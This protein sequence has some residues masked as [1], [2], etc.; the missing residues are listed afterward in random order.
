M[1]HCAGYLYLP[2]VSL[3]YW[4]KIHHYLQVW[5]QLLIVQRDGPWKA[6]ITALHLFYLEAQN[7]AELTQLL[8]FMKSEQWQSKRNKGH[9]Q[10]EEKVSMTRTSGSGLG[11]VIRVRYSPVVAQWALSDETAPAGQAASGFR[12]GLKS[13]GQSSVQKHLQQGCRIAWRKLY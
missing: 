6:I 3:L 1:H 2:L 12:S 10:V 4:G 8:R 7:W 11:R 13:G 9:L 5:F